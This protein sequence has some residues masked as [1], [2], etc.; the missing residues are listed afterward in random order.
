MSCNAL[1]IVASLPAIAVIC[2]ACMNC[3]PVVVT[4]FGS[5]VH[6]Y[7]AVLLIGSYVC[8]LAT[9]GALWRAQSRRQVRGEQKMI[10]WEKEDQKL[11]VEVASDEVKLLKAKIDT[12]EVA[13][14]SALKK[15]KEQK[16]S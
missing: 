14:K 15:S 1:L 3:T 10:K 8:G 7:E 6:V 16:N 9:T 4:L 12:L 2:L 11:M 13:L 5:S